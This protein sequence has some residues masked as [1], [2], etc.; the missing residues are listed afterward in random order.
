MTVMTLKKK[1]SFVILGW[2]LGWTLGSPLDP[3]CSV[4]YWVLRWILGTLLD[5]GCG[6]FVLIQ[7]GGG[8]C[9]HR[10]IGGMAALPSYL[11]TAAKQQMKA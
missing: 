11:S 2:I 4:G 5:P 7:S 8:D 9:S 3:G 1:A 10:Y 6:K